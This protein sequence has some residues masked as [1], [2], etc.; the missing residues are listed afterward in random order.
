MKLD[1][2]NYKVCLIH[3]DLNL[4]NVFLEK[5]GIFLIDWT[6]CR[7]D[8]PSCDVSQVFYL[9][10]LNQEQE[11]LFLKYYDMDFIDKQLLVYHKILLLLYDLA[12]TNIKK[13]VLEN[14]HASELSLEC[15]RYYE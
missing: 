5:R 13:Q 7:L 10:G 1:K 12:S 14:K 6:D 15:S 4:H 2:R 8:V 9:W 11:E 3:G